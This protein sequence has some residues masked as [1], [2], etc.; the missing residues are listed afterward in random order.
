M[1]KSKIPDPLER[2]HLIEREQPPAQS[3]RLAEAYLAEGRT[4]EAV[5]FLRKAGEREKLAAIRAEAVAAG[6]AFL[7]RI[8]AAALAEPV[9]RESW[10]Q[11]AEAA[12]AAGQ[13][14]YAADARRQ[15]ARGED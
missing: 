7:L 12:E 1:A 6:D 9:D 3:L 10:R 8:A 15:A 14:R 11:A 13:Q 5:D 4:L 2:R